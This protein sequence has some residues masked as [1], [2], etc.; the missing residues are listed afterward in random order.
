MERFAQ[1]M[2]RL[3]EEPETR[4]R[5]AQAG[6]ALFK[7]RLDISAI[8]PRMLALYRLAAERKAVTGARAVAEARLVPEEVVAVY[9]HG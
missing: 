5:L 3:I 9:D 8:A 2:A 7:D 4:I 1:P 6:H